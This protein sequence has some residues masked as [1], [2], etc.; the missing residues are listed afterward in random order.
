MAKAAATAVPSCAIFRS[1]FRPGIC[2]KQCSCSWA[3]PARAIASHA[4]PSPK[5][6]PARCQRLRKLIAQGAAHVKRELIRL[7]KLLLDQQYRRRLDET[8]GVRQAVERD[9]DA[10]SIIEVPINGFSLTKRFRGGVA[11]CARQATGAEFHAAEPSD[12]HHRDVEEIG[13]FDRGENRPPGG[14]RRLARIR[15]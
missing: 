6:E 14:S 10:E 13:S 2:S 9:D 3:A 4:Q 15:A 11:V 7:A 8:I 5:S 1:S 12:D